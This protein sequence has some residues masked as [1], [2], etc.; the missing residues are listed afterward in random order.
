[1]SAGRTAD[2]REDAGREG[3]GRQGTGREGTGREG[4]R[5][6]FSR[7]APPEAPRVAVLIPATDTAVE[8]ELPGLLGGRAG[9]HVARMRLPSVTLDGLLALEE[10]A[11]RQAE[12]LAPIRPALTVFACTSGSFVRG[13]VYEDRLTDRL[14][15]ATGAP[16]VTA[17]RAMVT[18]LRA[19]GGR[20]RLRASYTEDIVAAERRYLES[21][22]L[23]VT[24]ARGLGITEDEET[25]RVGAGELI[26]F[27]RDAPPGDDATVTMLSCTNLRTAEVLA[28]LRQGIGLPVVSSNLA[29]A[30]AVRE[31]LGP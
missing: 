18:A 17:A 9:L 15:A 19:E 2:G 23:T 1:M 21:F 7:P 13:R 16:V 30:A 12:A 8:R 3:A 6:V 22:G 10:D 4:T 27:A 5:H 14:A 31:A 20:V 25:A 28:E 29:L 11:V 24:D 26:R